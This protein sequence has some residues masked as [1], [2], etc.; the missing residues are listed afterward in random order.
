MGAAGVYLKYAAGDRLLF[1]RPFHGAAWSY[2]AGFG[3]YYRLK[4]LCWTKHGEK[5]WGG[6]DYKPAE[7]IGNKTSSNPFHKDYQNYMASGNKTNAP[8]R[9]ESL[10]GEFVAKSVDSD[11]PIRF[12]SG[13]DSIV[14]KSESSSPN[15]RYLRVVA[16]N[17]GKLPQWHPGKGGDSYLFVDEIVIE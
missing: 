5:M 11:Y 17:P 9:V 6:I 2:R 14:Y 4:L 16:K 1:D 12:L 10:P 13:G 7:L 8:A 15:S 3:L